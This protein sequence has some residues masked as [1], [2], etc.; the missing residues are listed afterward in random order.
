MSK[1]LHTESSTGWG[2]QEL[3]IARES[4]QLKALGFDVVI[5]ASTNSQFGA[6][7]PAVRT[8]LKTAEIGRKSFQGVIAMVRVLKLVDPDLVITHSS[9]DSWLVAV[10]ALLVKPRLKIVRYRHVSAPI[11][12]NIA[13]KWLY[14]RADLLVTT[15]DEIR[16]MIIRQI[17][18]SKNNICSIPTGIDPGALECAVA[19]RELRAYY[20]FSAQ[21]FVVGMVATLRSWKG[22][23]DV[24]KAISTCGDR[25]KLLIVGDG[26]QMENLKSQVNSLGL[27]KR[28]VFVGHVDDVA[29]FFK[30]MDVFCQP[31]LR[32]EGVSQAVLQAMFA[33]TPVIATAIGGLCEVVS[34]DSA[35]VVTPGDPTGISIAIEELLGDRELG[36][37][38]AKR[39]REIVGERHSFERMVARCV[40]AYTRI[41]EN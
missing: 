35:K 31:S 41:L 14:K 20:N 33:E 37:L 30:L 25:V 10:S 38:L 4:L 26:P 16:D 9:T 6:R 2:G 21:D 8:I 39:A 11:S 3:R 18:V 36:Y 1:I 28:V 34:S 15:S 22:H 7:F 19:K 32:N 29:P 24:I 13:T 5:C 17:G 23:S 12:P 40:E 27:E